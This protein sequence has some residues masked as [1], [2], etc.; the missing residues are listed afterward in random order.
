ML[1]EFAEK[2]KHF[3]NMRIFEMWQKETFTASASA[4]IVFHKHPHIV[5]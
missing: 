5:S 4:I 2:K 1:S 3:E